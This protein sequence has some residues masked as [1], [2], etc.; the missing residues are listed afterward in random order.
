MK[1]I[2]LPLQVPDWANWL[3]IDKFGVVECWRK[4]PEPQGRYG[5]PG[6]WMFGGKRMELVAFERQSYRNWRKSLRQI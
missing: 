6:R 4:Q 2:S 1:T 3:T 5:E